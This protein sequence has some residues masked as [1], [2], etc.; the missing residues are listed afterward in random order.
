MK[1]TNTTAAAGIGQI[2]EPR[3]P[4]YN[5]VGQVI[6]R[7]IGAVTA[8]IAVIAESLNSANAN[9]GPAALEKLRVSSGSVANQ[10]A[11]LADFVP[12]VTATKVSGRVHALNLVDS[13]EGAY[14]SAEKI[15]T[16]ETN[17]LTLIE[18]LDAYYS[19]TMKTGST[20]DTDYT[21]SA[22]AVVLDQV[23]GRIWLVPNASDLGDYFTDAAEIA[24]FS[25][26]AEAFME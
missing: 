18:F 9:V 25:A 2:F 13:S 21:P 6:R 1:L 3:K 22:E 24:T 26:G 4:V 14:L 17:N 15:G 5:G 19:G 20:L 8:P 7:L 16:A 12:Y 11:L 10:S 23:N